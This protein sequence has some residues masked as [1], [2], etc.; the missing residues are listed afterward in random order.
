[1]TKRRLAKGTGSADGSPKKS[2]RAATVADAV[3]SAAA[4]GEVS[5]SSVPSRADLFMENSSVEMVIL[6][7][8]TD[9]SIYGAQF[10]E[11]D[12]KVIHL[13]HRTKPSAFYLCMRHLGDYLQ[14]RH[15]EDDQFPGTIGELEIVLKAKFVY[16]KGQPV[17][18]DMHGLFVGY[19][20]A[21]YVQGDVDACKEV[22]TFLDAFVT[23][24]VLQS[25][26]SE[27]TNLSPPKID[28][29]A[30]PE[31]DMQLKAAEGEQGQGD[32][33]CAFEVTHGDIHPHVKITDAPPPT[34]P[35][36]MLVA[37]LEI[38]SNKTLSI[39]WSGNTMPF[40]RCFEALS[41]GG[42]II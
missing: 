33:D 14:E 34:Y 42:K 2:T 32:M 9:G 30:P 8:N 41:I 1:M 39:V 6:H 23:W 16:T 25:D 22:I 37:N 21:V 4:L 7:Y 35:A 19:R 12:M 38:F 17:D 36:R 26:F 3:P 40:K 31:F 5:T 24:R 28:I 10:G 18:E 27:H 15:T 13:L 29:F 20:N 11:G